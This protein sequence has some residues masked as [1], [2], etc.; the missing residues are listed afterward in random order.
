MM[1]LDSSD[2]INT[3][4]LLTQSQSHPIKRT[5]T[6]WTAVAHIVTGVIGSGVLSLPWSI[7]QLGWIVGPFSILLIASS[8]LYSAFLLCNTY[9]SP[10]PEYG[11]HRSASYLDVVNFNLGTGNGRLCGFLVNIC[12]YGFGIAFV[13]TTAI[14]LR[15]IQISIS[16]HNKENETPSEFA[17]AYYML[18]FGIVQIALSQIPNL[19]DIHWLSVVAAITSF[20]YCFIGMGLS[21]MQIIENGYAKGSIEGISTSSGTEKLWLVSQALGDVSFS[22]PFSTIMMEIQ[23]TLKTP[24]PENQTMKKASTISVAITTFFYLVCGWA[25]YAAFGD[26]TPGNLLTGFGSS[27]F[28]WLVGFAHA[29]IVVHLVGS[30]QVYCQPLFA[31]AENWFR[32]NFPDSEFVNHTYTLKLPLLPAFKLNFLSLSFRTAYVA[33]TVVIAM[34]FPYF[35]QILGVLGSISYWPLTIYFPVTVYLSRSDTDA[36]TAKWVMLQAFNVFGFVFGL[37]TLIGCIRGIV[38]E[39]LG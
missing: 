26:N 6:L 29:C 35:N 12:I 14:S 13:I 11:P 8:T 21:I 4:L 10:N 37:F 33:S 9:R 19:H 2:N 28:Y 3:P 5:G 25:G 36:W 38:T 18:I 7:A 34:I 27:K 30:Y 15:A 20:G 31:N 17:D 1:G 32:L 24:P 16:Q 39:K 23:D 22:Y